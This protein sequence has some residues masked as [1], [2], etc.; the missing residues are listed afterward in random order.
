MLSSEFLSPDWVAKPKSAE[1]QGGWCRGYRSG[2][3]CGWGQGWG[4]GL[5]GG[6]KIKPGWGSG[7][8]K[9]GVWAVGSRVSF[10]KPRSSSRMFSHFRC[11]HGEGQGG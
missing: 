6:L 11:L 8:D 5:L 9:G 7:W 3:K 10:R 2:Y 1:V 4:G